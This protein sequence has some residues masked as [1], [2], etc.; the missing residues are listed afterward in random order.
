[1]YQAGAGC[2]VGSCFFYTGR[3]QALP[4]RL[5]G[6]NFSRLNVLYPVKGLFFRYN[7]LFLP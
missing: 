7:S 2:E 3:L 5:L 1:M 6:C 4:Y